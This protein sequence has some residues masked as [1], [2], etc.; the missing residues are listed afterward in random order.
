MI[1]TVATLASRARLLL[2]SLV[3]AGTGAAEVDFNRDVRPIL[4]DK[5]FHCHGPDEQGR[6]AKLR[7]DTREGALRERDGARVILPGRGA[8]S[9]LLLRVLSPHADEVMPPPEAKIGRLT[10][11]EIDTLRRWIDAGA[12]YQEHWAFVPPVAPAL[13]PAELRAGPAARNGVDQLVFAA[14][15]RR[16]LA[17]QPEADR[18]TLLRRVTFDLTGL[19]PS[20]AELATFLADPAPDAYA[21]A[22]DRLLASPRYGER[23][24]ADWLDLARYA[25]SFGFQVDREWAMWPWR[26]WVMQS[27]NRNLPWD[28]FVTWQ[29]AGDLLQI[30]RAHV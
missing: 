24:A 28:Q 8:E 11:A 16:N 5:C 22:V 19:P 30:G 12:P 21:R 23:M 6:K 17:P 20:P 2:A 15:R 9:E 26:D 25:D 14:L 29:L 10:P 4:S 27:F 18:A 1:P 13:P 3:V 7:L